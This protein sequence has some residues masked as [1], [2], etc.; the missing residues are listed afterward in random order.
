MVPFRTGPFDT[1]DNE[2]CRCGDT[3]LVTGESS[4]TKGKLLDESLLLPSYEVSGSGDM[5]GSLFVS[6][7]RCNDATN[8]PINDLRLPVIDIFRVR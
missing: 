8:F 3:S 5:S 7:C 1:D 4:T 6:M 2:V